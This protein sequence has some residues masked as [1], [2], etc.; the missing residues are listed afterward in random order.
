[1][2]LLSSNQNATSSLLSLAGV[3]P[4]HILGCQIN[5]PCSVEGKNYTGGLIGRGDGVYLTKSN[6]DNLSKVSYFKNNIFSMDG[7]EEKIS[8]LM[9]WNPWMVKIVLVVFLAQW[10]QQV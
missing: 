7:I 10:E 8:L 2:K 3:S 1:M 4:S 5:A 9:V 6:T